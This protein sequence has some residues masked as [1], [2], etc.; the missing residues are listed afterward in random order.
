MMSNLKYKIVSLEWQQ[1][2]KLAFKSLQVDMSVALTFIEGG[3]DKGRDF[4]FN[5]NNNFFGYGGRD[6]KYIFQVKHKSFLDSFKK[7]LEDLVDELNKVFVKNKLEYDVYCL[8]TNLTISGTQYDQLY[9]TFNKFIASNLKE[10]NLK[11]VIY[12][13]QNFESCIDKN[14]F[15][16]WSFPSIVNKVDFKHLIQQL[17]QNTDLITSEIWSKVFEK[18][19]INFVHTDIF[20]HA[21]KKLKENNIVLLSGPSKSGKT[22][23]AEM[24][25]FFY[26]STKSYQI[27]KIDNLQ[28]LNRCY[29]KSQNQVFLLDDAFGRYNLDDSL[30]DNFD[31]KLGYLSELTDQTHKFVF[32]S[33]EYIYKAF[34]NYSDESNLKFIEKINIEVHLL[35]IYEKESI[36]LRYLSYSVPLVENNIDNEQ[37]EQIV[38]H[39]NFSPETIRAYFKKSI[40][41]NF[42]SILNHLDSPDDYLEKDFKNLND[43]KKNCSFSNSIIFK[44]N[45]G[46][47]FLYL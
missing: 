47:Y 8:V 25:L 2:E 39:K 32:T 43:D 22:F 44:W 40:S 12:S 13:Y 10:R 36:F 5:G 46:R 29:V 18:N 11:L 34:L 42:V 28:E 37:L 31:R 27:Y 14:D 15:L 35:T 20:E 30:A 23:T 45:N 17:H 33:R 41:F 7:L 16:K 24:I 1:F 21:L 4:V 3:S 26:F 9:E 6:L 19:R 38:N